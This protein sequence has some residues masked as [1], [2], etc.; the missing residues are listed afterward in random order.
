MTVKIIV[1]SN[2]DKVIGNVN[3]NC[4]ITNILSVESPFILR[5]IMTP[6]GYSMV[7]LPLIP[8]T[9]TEIKIDARHI[10]VHPCNPKEELLDMY[11]QMTSNIILP[12]SNSGI[13]LV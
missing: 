12:K 4:N 3:E 5:E 11:Q 10:M 2:G 6:E 7:P 13:K 9:D 1:L 8:T